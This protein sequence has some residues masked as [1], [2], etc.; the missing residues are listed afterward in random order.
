MAGP[1]SLSAPK[2]RTSKR[3]AGLRWP[4]CIHHCQAPRTPGAHRRPAVVQSI[5]RPPFSTQSLAACRRHATQDDFVEGKASERVAFNR[6]GFSQRRRRREIRPCLPQAASRSASS[7][8]S[9]V[10]QPNPEVSWRT[11]A[12]PGKSA[13]RMERTAARCHLRPRRN[14]SS[15]RDIGLTV[16]ADELRDR[17]RAAGL[18]QFRRNEPSC[19]DYP[20]YETIIPINQNAIEFLDLN[21]VKVTRGHG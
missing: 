18:F 15:I 5:D 14:N 17:A 20:L 11:P 8:R 21:H 3:A 9:R 7:T 12:F 10:R 16:F 13:R 6:R 1:R 2:D 19:R 4:D